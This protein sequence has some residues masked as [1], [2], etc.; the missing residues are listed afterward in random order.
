METPCAREHRVYNIECVK[1]FECILAFTSYGRNVRCVL[2]RGCSYFGASEI[3]GAPF[4][5]HFEPWSAIG[6]QP[7]VPRSTQYRSQWPDEMQRCTEYHAP[8]VKHLSG[9]Q[10]HTI[11]HLILKFQVGDICTINIYKFQC[12]MF[13]PLCNSITR[14]RLT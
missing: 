14:L 10:C 13:T 6:F 11:V 3:I 7:I 12:A 9:A 5:D 2:R 4:F 1:D 8:T